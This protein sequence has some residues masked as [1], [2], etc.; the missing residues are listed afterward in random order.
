MANL[1]LRIKRLESQLKPAADADRVMIVRFVDA[2][3]HEAEIQRLADTAGNIWTRS[4]D[5]TEEQLVARAR[6]EA[7]RTAGCLPLLLADVA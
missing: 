7:P 2:G 1:A 6:N 5:E 4:D 3:G